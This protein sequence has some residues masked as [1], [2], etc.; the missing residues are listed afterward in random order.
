MAF[1]VNCVSRGYFELMGIPIRQGRAIDATDRD[2]TL[3]VAVVNEAFARRFWGSADPVGRRLQVGGADLTVAGVAMDGKYEF[4]APLDAASP[5]FVYLPFSQWGHFEVTLHVRTAGDPLA[6]VPSIENAVPYLPS[7]LASLVLTVLGAAALV[8][9]TLGLYAVTAYAVTQRR[10][11]IGIR[12]ALGATPARIAAHVL[13]YAGRH[14]GAGALAGVLL[15]LAMARGL[16]TQ[17]P[18]SLPRVTGNQ[19]WPFATASAVLG[20]VAALAALIAATRAARMNPAA[21]L[22][23][24]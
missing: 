11:E 10:R 20:T 5:P 23:E 8:F 18:D 7:Q 19:V 1:L 6:L 12:M 9:A 3:P 17:L 16:A 21:A 15:A 22:R 14:A 2:G 4:L 24:E 13:A